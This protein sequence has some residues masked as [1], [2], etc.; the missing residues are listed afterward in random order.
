MPP[1]LP[2]FVALLQLVAFHPFRH[3]ADDRIAVLPELAGTDIVQARLVPCDFDHRHLQAEAYA[4]KRHFSF[5]G[6]LHCLDLALCAAFAEA[7]RHQ[8][9]VNI[10]E[11][12]VCNLPSK[13][14]DPANSD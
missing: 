5:A 7:A 9:A 12:S 2:R 6:E 3:Q 8:N 11:R 13:I 1:R 14:S 4:K 10:L